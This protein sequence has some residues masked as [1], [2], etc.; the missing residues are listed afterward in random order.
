[1]QGAVT[2][3]TGTAVG[4]GLFLA[5][6]HSNICFVPCMCLHRDMDFYGLKFE[7]TKNVA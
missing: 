2:Q 6:L 4:A 7:L 3:L 1:M 5:L